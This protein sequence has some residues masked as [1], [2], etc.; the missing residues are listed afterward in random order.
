[1]WHLMTE[2]TEKLTQRLADNEKKIREVLSW[3]G[4]KSARIWGIPYEDSEPQPD[5]DVVVCFDKDICGIIVVM[6]DKFRE[7][8][9]RRSG[10]INTRG[11]EN[12]GWLIVRLSLLLGCV[13][14][15]C[16]ERAVKNFHPETYKQILS[17]CHWDYA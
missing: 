3:S 1:M 13:V 14:N 12:W 15:L 4:A 8:R 2:K 7:P 6:R 16:E 5:L 17:T 9:L 11:K 10:P